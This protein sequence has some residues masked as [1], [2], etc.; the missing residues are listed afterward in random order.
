MN[1]MITFVF[2]WK[3]S[4]PTFINAMNGFVQG[5]LGT[6]DL[7][8][9][10]K[11]EI[12]MDS[13]EQ[14]EQDCARI[15]KENEKTLGEFEKWLSDK[16]LSSKTVANHRDNVDFYINE[17]LLYEEAQEASE[18]IDSINYFLG[19]WF[20]KKAMWASKSSIKNNAT[21]IKKFYEFMYEKGI[22]D[23]YAYNELKE[24]MKENMQDWLDTMDRYDDPAIEDMEEV[25]GL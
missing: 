20:I 23:A 7:K 2:R 16:K 24:E 6:R 18:G 9:T 15:R 8:T 4:L 17:F 12:E 19:F 22:V 3:V 11:G 1:K 10:D 5:W 21:S 13:Y 14:Y 25:W